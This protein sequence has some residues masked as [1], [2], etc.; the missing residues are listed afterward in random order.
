[1]KDVNTPLRK[2]YVDAISATMYAGTYIKVYDG[3]VPDSVVAGRE[4]Y[5]YVLIAD[6]TDND[7]VRTKNMISHDSTI[8]V[9]VYN[10]T[11]GGSGRK[12]VDDVAGLILDAVN[13]V[14]SSGFLNLSA[15]N[16]D[17]VTTT[18]I[19]DV[20][21]LFSTKSHKVWRRNIRFRHNISE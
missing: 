5:L 6:Q 2:A 7:S 20:T 18:V 14:T 16:L 15:S 19:S 13:S 11:M 17:I 12:K 21:D 4:E 10:G 8:M 3:I 9:Q 1:L